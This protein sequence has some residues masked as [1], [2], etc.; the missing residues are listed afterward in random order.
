MAK[1]KGTKLADI[2]TGTAKADQIF[3]LA[4]NDTLIG[5]AGNDLLDGGKGKDKMSGGKGNDTYI[6]DNAG[7]KT[8]EKAGQGTD[9]VKSSITHTLSANV[10][11]LTLTGAAAIDGTGNALANTITGNAGNNHLDGGLGADI[12]IGGAG[13]DTYVVDNAGDTVSDASGTDTVQSSITY[14]LGAGIENLTLTGAAAID[15]TGNDLDNTITGNS[16][17]NQL[18]GGA[19][20]DSLIGGA[21][22]NNLFGG[23]GDDTLSGADGVNAF[24]GGG[25]ID[26]ADYSGVTST[27]GVIVYASA[28]NGTS[29]SRAAAGDTFSSIEKFIGTANNDFFGFEIVGFVNGGAGDDTLELYGGGTA[30]GDEGSDTLRISGVAAAVYG[31]DGNDIIELFAEASTAYG[32]AGDDTINFAS[33]TANGN[34]AS[35]GAGNDTFFVSSNGIANGDDGN[36]TFVAKLGFQSF[37]GGEGNDT[38]DF[39]NITY[40]V[41]ASLRTTGIN[42]LDYISDGATIFTYTIE[43]IENLT[44]GKG[45]DHLGGDDNANVIIGGPGNDSIFGGG[46]ADRFVVRSASDNS[47]TIFDFSRSQGDKLDFSA[48]AGTFQLVFGTP[49]GGGVMSI[50]VSASGSTNFVLVDG[51]GDGSAEIVMVVQREA[52]MGAFIASDFIL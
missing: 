35:G 21:G 9:T 14:T 23:A 41:N 43:N 42:S 17:D 51:N 8:I 38:A 4:G 40:T 50:G 45:T 39:S 10:E 15:G 16:G 44:G 37:Y 22:T 28:F 49:L 48:F 7:D 31:G 33:T 11:N 24:H 18:D 47:D 34:V 12:L 30:F 2:L 26:T 25:G 6:V 19:G 27:D 20:N 1:I 5:L 52:G 13:D 46:G 32:G 29:G 3:G 36:D